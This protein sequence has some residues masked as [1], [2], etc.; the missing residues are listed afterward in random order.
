MHL[1]D[2]NVRFNDERNIIELNLPFIFM[3]L[4]FYNWIQ[5]KIL[6]LVLTVSTSRVYKYSLFIIGPK[7]MLCFPWFANDMAMMIYKHFQK[8]F[9]NHDIIVVSN[10]FMHCKI[11]QF[12]GVEALSFNQL[13]LV[14]SYTKNIIPITIKKNLIVICWLHCDH[15]APFTVLVSFM[16]IWIYNRYNMRFRFVDS[17][18]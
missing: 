15:A 5:E 3:K 11:K 8:N 6:I 1:D 4:H 13:L 16:S 10:N 2:N 9:Q 18:F 14:K 12:C 17:L 7:S